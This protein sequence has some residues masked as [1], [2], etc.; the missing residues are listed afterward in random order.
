MLQENNFD[1]ADLMLYIRTFNHPNI[2]R[3][4]EDSKFELAKET[5]LNE[6]QKFANF[7]NVKFN[8]TKFDVLKTNVRQRINQLCS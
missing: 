5:V 7:S 1:F 4:T 6:Y 2:E 3:R 8:Q